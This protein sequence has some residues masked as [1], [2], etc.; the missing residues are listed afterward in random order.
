M[1]AIGVVGFFRCGDD[2][3]RAEDQ[4]RGIGRS[5]YRDCGAVGV[6]H[7]FDV[8]VEHADRQVMVAG[9]HAAPLVGGQTV[10][11]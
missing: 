5:L 6:D 3:Q 11:I 8:A 7:A 10:S 9:T 2:A 1:Q 4:K